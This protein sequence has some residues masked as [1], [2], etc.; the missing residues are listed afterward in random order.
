MKTTT[1]DRDDLELYRRAVEVLDAAHDPVVHQVAAALRTN[2]GQVFVGLH[3]G[4]RRVNVCAEASAIA[5]AEMSKAGPVSAIVAVC[6]ND[7]GRT[8]V[9]N[10][11]GLCRELLGH[12]GPD[13]GVL[14]DRGGDV[15]KVAAADLMPMPWMFP[16]ENDWDVADPSRA[17]ERAPDARS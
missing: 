2:D 10:P 1:L 14:V 13:A 11:C 7:A 15:V 6:R 12:Y 9:T 5:N 3:V 17:D 4:S 16:H 8:I